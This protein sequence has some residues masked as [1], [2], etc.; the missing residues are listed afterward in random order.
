MPERYDVIIIGTGAG[1]GTLAHRLASSG[2]RILLLERGDHVPREAEN[3]SSLEAVRRER[4]HANDTWLDAHGRGFRPG[5]HYN[6]GG[7]TKFYGA[8]LFRMRESDF[9]DVRHDGGM[10]P[11]WPVGYDEFEPYYSEAE[12]LYE[13]RG[14][15]GVDPTEPRRRS[16]YP[17]SEVPHEPRMQE[18]HDH[19][20]SIGLRPFHV[21]LGVRLDPRAPGSSRCVRCATC[22]GFPCLVRA[23]SDAETMCVEPACA[24]PEVTLRT[25]AK[26]TR[27]LAS[28]SGR[29]I[30]GVEVER[31]GALEEYRADL[32]VVAAGAVN[33]AALLLRSRCDRHPNGVGN[34]NDLVGRHYMAHNNS[35][36]FVFS[37]T[38][39][40]TRFQKTL[41][42]NDFYEHGPD[43]PNDV[44]LG[45]ISMVGK[46]DGHMFKTG[47]PAFV[48]RWVLDRMG[49]RSLDFWITSEDL[50]DPAN[51]VTLEGDGQIRL[52]Y[53]ENNLRAHRRLIATLKRS[54]ATFDRGRWFSKGGKVPLA[55]VAHQCGTLRFGVDPTTSVLDRDCRVHG[56]SNLFVADGS[57]F[58]SSSAVNPALTIIA[59]ALRV[60]DVIRRD[61]GVGAAVASTRAATRSL[62]VV[63]A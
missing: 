62:P 3:W 19:F 1:G 61:L 25:R 32:V 16:P 63:R 28:S 47:A 53:R 39:N 55:G 6:V 33:S 2:K 4:Y 7:N 54:L 13:V 27:L 31:D 17:H 40:P 50:P 59:N 45:H 29:E 58:P 24:D 38:R 35:V 14:R 37:A 49:E 57:F 60:G 41:A 43:G 22:D 23:K 21:P 12:A 52:A 51:R 42:L 18:L 26:A 36:L 5:T 34:A 48:P 30:V 56:V 20:A 11:A 46:F 44:P 15:A 10:S 8:A 9:R